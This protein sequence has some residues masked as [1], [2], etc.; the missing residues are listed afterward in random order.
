MS[1]TTI[2]AETVQQR[3]EALWYSAY[4]EM[5]PINSDPVEMFCELTE[6]REQGYEITEIIKWLNNKENMNIP[7]VTWI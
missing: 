1:V 5:P 7:G 4:G 6:D 3:L 2:N